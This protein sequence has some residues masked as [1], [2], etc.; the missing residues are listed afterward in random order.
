MKRLIEVEIISSKA[1]KRTTVRFT[2]AVVG[3]GGNASERVYSPGVW[4]CSRLD[5]AL[6]EGIVMG[7]I[8]AGCPITLTNASFSRFHPARR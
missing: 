1:A 8:R 2:R 6:T 5:N 7:R 4:S 3:P